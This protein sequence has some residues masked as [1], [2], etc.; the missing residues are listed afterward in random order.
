[1]EKKR[2]MPPNNPDA[3]P[4]KMVTHA[5]TVVLDVQLP[6]DTSVA[7][8]KEAV[9]AHLSRELDPPPPNLA[10]DIF[11]YQKPGEVEGESGYLWLQDQEQLW[12]IRGQDWREGTVRF[13]MLR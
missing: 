4:K 9:A 13:A 1:M 8:V 5:D 12:D 3:K 6:R 10:R 2:N 7:A 11:L